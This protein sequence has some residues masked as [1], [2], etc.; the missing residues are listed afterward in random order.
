M[1]SKGRP[2]KETSKTNQ[3]R[4]RMND[5]EMDML[6]H[7]SVETGEKKSDILRKALRNYYLLIVNK[8]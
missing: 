5:K 3:Y 6:N 8:Y 1:N 7:L 4:L 2:K